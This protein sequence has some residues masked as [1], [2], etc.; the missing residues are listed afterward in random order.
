MKEIW[1]DNHQI[2]RLLINLIYTNKTS[3]SYA[4]IHTNFSED[5]QLEINTS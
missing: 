2:H 5:V 1:N 3:A 4:Q